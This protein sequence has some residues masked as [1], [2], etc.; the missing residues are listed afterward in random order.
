MV[1]WIGKASRMV[2]LEGAERNARDDA[3]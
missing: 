2:P 1:V 3:R